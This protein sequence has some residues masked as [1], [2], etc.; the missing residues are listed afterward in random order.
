MDRTADPHSSE[1]YLVERYWPDVDLTQVRDA[2]SRLDA[3]VSVMTAEGMTIAH[4]GSILMPADQVVFS[5]I[6]AG[7]ESLVR[8]LNE[9]AGLPVDRIA[10]AIA[11]LGR[12][13]GVLRGA[14]A[15]AGRPIRRTD[16]LAT[17][18]HD[19]KGRTR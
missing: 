2:M 3:A 13:A 7:D 16:P 8:Q 12:G 1:T 9:R 10:R 17:S 14:Q 4:V 18:P 6:V 19:L 11:L 15:A 5:L